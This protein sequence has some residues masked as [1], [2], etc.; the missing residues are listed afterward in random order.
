M[1]TLNK[2]R[3]IYAGK[4]QLVLAT[5]FNFSPLWNEIQGSL[6]RT[7]NNEGQLNG[8]DGI[9]NSRLI[10]SNAEILSNFLG[11]LGDDVYK[12]NLRL[13]RFGSSLY[14]ASFA[15]P[16]NNSVYTVQKIDDSPPE[17]EYIASSS[18]TGRYFGSY[19]YTSAVLSQAL[20]K[21]FQWIPIQDNTCIVHPV[22]MSNEVIASNQIPDVDTLPIQNNNG[23]FYSDTK[24]DNAVETI[25]CDAEY[26]IS[27]F[28]DQVNERVRNTMRIGFIL[29]TT[30]GWR[31]YMYVPSQFTMT[32]QSFPHWTFQMREPAKGLFVPVYKHG[33]GYRSTFAGGGTGLTDSGF[34]YGATPPSSSNRNALGSGFPDY[35]DTGG[36]NSMYDVPSAEFLDTTSKKRMPSHGFGKA[37]NRVA[38]VNN[39]PLAGG[40]M[41]ID[42]VAIGGVIPDDI[43]VDDGSGILEGA[44]YKIPTAAEGIGADEDYSSWGGPPANE[45]TEGLVFKATDGIP[46]T[47]NGTPIGGA[48]GATQ[49]LLKL[50][51]VFVDTGLGYDE[52][53]NG[54]GSDNV[55]FRGNGKLI[56]VGGADNTVVA[57]AKY[58][59]TSDGAGANYTN[60]V[61][62]DDPDLQN[63]GIPANY[64]EGDTFI[65]FAGTLDGAVGNGGP[66]GSLEHPTA[67]ALGVAQP[68]PPPLQ[69]SQQ[70]RVDPPTAQ[71]QGRLGHILN[72]TRFSPNSI[73]LA[74]IDEPLTNVHATQCIGYLD[75]Y[76]SDHPNNL[77]PRGGVVYTVTAD[78]A[79]EDYS[80]ID[81]APVLPAQYVEGYSFTTVA[82]PTALDS[83]LAGPP[84]GTKY[85]IY[86]YFARLGGRNG[87]VID[88]KGPMVSVKTVAGVLNE[89]R[90]SGVDFFFNH[91]TAVDNGSRYEDGDVLTIDNVS[92]LTVGAETAVFVI[93]KF[94]R[95]AIADAKDPS[96]GT[97]MQ[98]DYR[99][100][101]AGRIVEYEASFGGS[102]IDFENGD[103]VRI[104]EGLG[105]AELLIAA[106]NT[107][108]PVEYVEAAD[109]SPAGAGMDMTVD[110]F[111]DNGVSSLGFQD[112]T[113]WADGSELSIS[114]VEMIRINNAG[115][116]QYKCGDI[117]KVMSGNED[118]YFKICYTPELGN[119]RNLHKRQ[120]LNVWEKVWYRHSRREYTGLFEAEQEELY[121]KIRLA[122]SQRSPV[123]FFS[124]GLP[125]DHK[126]IQDGV[127][128]PNQGMR[129]SEVRTFNNI[130]TMQ[131]CDLNIWEY[132]NEAVTGGPAII[133]DDVIIPES[134]GLY[135]ILI[136][137]NYQNISGNPD[138]VGPVGNAGKLIRVNIGG[139]L[140][141]GQSIKLAGF[142]DS[143]D[144]DGYGNANSLNPWEVPLRDGN[145]EG[146]I[147]DDLPSHARVMPMFGKSVS[148]NA[149]PNKETIAQYEEAANDWSEPVSGS[150]GG[151]IVFG[152][153]TDGKD[154]TFARAGFKE[155]GFKVVYGRLINPTELPAYDALHEVMIA[156][157][158]SSLSTTV[159]A[160]AAPIGFILRTDIDNGATKTGSKPVPIGLQLRQIRTF[161]S[162]ASDSGYACD[163]VVSIYM[164]ASRVID[165]DGE[166]MEIIMRKGVLGATGDLI[167]DAGSGTSEVAKQNMRLTA[168]DF[169]A[170][171]GFW[172]QGN[173]DFDEQDWKKD[174]CNEEADS[175]IVSIRRK[176]PT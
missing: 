154:T 140:A 54:V 171:G 100:D 41:T 149:N 3:I 143:F 128:V 58:R 44:I 31:G 163:E 120:P 17:D 23:R 60:L 46:A 16:I 135:R 110:I 96:T 29:H 45:A 141:T 5:G 99:V 1:T 68:V 119:G 62:L 168:S 8:G 113:G 89:V 175:L 98:I 36:L 93:K 125:I 86:E 61:D 121:Y 50:G 21:W 173:K 123:D 30:I 77:T 92:D 164:G 130:N 84:S 165:P 4:Q 147:V 134:G 172:G 18:Q 133:G 20:E 122:S 80:E 66:M 63:S 53:S 162:I 137:G 51:V 55:T 116:G 150:V 124:K 24:N 15:R 73:G 22:N 90:V 97:G 13:V 43:F 142:D 7:G 72:T 38:T 144:A 102:G 105:G 152:A 153:I 139:A 160:G 32:S 42:F 145:A 106:S 12:G 167:P 129:I 74:N 28:G 83:L 34:A 81:I 79:G 94:H 35:V 40:G 107:D 161:E 169:G 10:S 157:D 108:I 126:L 39:K 138:A 52:N 76:A 174:D 47:T 114:G 69:S 148:Q 14:G 87:T 26:G 59:V 75:Y 117:L 109:G 25:W 91:P 156:G 158:Y 71:S 6:G 104:S 56:R 2:S 27:M 85:E 132:D 33:S 37:F 67:G 11:T 70:H 151:Q 170:I 118:C 65:A 176:L 112:I 159:G 155:Q 49:R 127:Q 146:S 95:F 136:E 9:D 131:Q 82:S 166:E 57:G 19:I 64:S 48:L 115:N 103:S 88:N 101:S 111:V 78:G